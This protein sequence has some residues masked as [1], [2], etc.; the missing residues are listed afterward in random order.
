[1][2]WAEALFNPKHVAVIGS[3]GAGKIGRVLVEQIVAGG[4]EG[5]SAI[6]PRGEGLSATSPAGAF[7]VSGFRSIEE[8]P[9][10]KRPELVVIA[11]PA[12]TVADVI[13]EAGRAGAKAAIVIT[14]G[15]RESGNAEGEARL[16]EAA[17]AAGIRLVGP[18]CAGI[19]NTKRNL[20]PTLE[21]RP[22][23][24]E[25]AFISQSGALGG[26]VLSWAEEQGVG[27]SKFVSYGNGADL[28]DVDF[29]E[30]LRLDHE[31]K[32]VAL[33]IETV[34]DGRRFMDAVRRLTAMKPLVVIKSGRSQVG[35]RA[36]L[37][38]TGSM[39]GA[40]G[41]YDAA[42]RQCGAL[43]V[44]GIEEM[45]DLCRGFVT[46]PPVRGKRLVVVTNSGGP[47]VLAAD[48]AEALGLEL[49]TPS[50][51]LR[52]RLARHLQPFCSLENPIDLTVQGDED[53]Y[54]EALVKA[55]DEADAALAIDVNTPY[56][57]AVPIARGVVDATRT[58]GKPI[59]TCFM[60]GETVANALP[61]LEAGG[62]PNFATGERAV[63]VFAAMARRTLTR[64]RLRAASPAV[65]AEPEKPDR[66][67]PWEGQGLEPEVL[68]W[69]ESDAFPV[70]RRLLAATADEAAEAV[71]SFGGPVAMKLVAEGLLHKSD[72]GGVVLDVADPAE[73]RE[74]FSRLRKLEGD[75]FRGI[76][77]LPMVRGAAEV[78]VGLSTDAQ[79]GPVVAVGLGGV[80]TEVL[81]DVALR[82][83]PID[84]AT[85]QE[86]LD[87]LHGA[88][89]LRGVRGTGARD[90]TSLSE[91]VAAIS[92]LPFRYRGLRELDLN[93]VFV[94]QDG[95]LI[96][97]ARAV[98]SSDCGA[99]RDT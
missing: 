31:T 21:T 62:V 71:S 42:L 83:A 68:D 15:F 17:R 2:T 86:M 6:N 80:H 77:V 57:D 82:V 25:V 13:A 74:T 34:S 67:L 92:R 58:A 72:V 29:L 64:E 65:W 85:A 76:L 47:A 28:T 4:F 96:G 56:L 88:A 39:A 22:P 90:L 10:D 99:T 5:V 52:E 20:F 16:C 19:I 79:F 27:F 61:F 12:N 48:R 30:A 35:G 84:P 51:A 78:L 91:M 46:L 89:I 60:A 23:R 66:D 70:P 87:E 9:S 37:S 3:V 14:A 50:P 94:L 1:M 24:G 53:D 8:I 18:N 93:P 38:H 69:L 45:F 54:R 44:D 98:R 63:A 73:A 11:S 43:R 55:L 7:E 41:V 95:V 36:A 75:R 26:A 33:Y 32:V 81:R 40:D 49:P 59:A 97:D